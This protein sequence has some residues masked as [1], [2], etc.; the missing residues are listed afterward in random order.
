M[1]SASYAV[2]SF[3][4]S[5]FIFQFL[6]VA[7]FSG[8]FLFCIVYCIISDVIGVIDCKPDIVEYTNDKNEEKVQL[9]FSIT[10]GR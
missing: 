4:F 3:I 6:L 1:T 5:F 8:F 2:C 7:T 10:D 9:K